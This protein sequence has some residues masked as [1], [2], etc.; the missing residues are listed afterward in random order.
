ML[1]FLAIGPARVSC[2]ELFPR[3]AP[4]RH[5][6]TSPSRSPELPPCV[7]PVRCS[8]ERLAC[9]PD[10]LAASPSLHPSPTPP[11][12]PPCSP[13]RLAF[14]RAPP[15]VLRSPVLPRASCVPPCSPERLAF[16]RAPRASCVPPCSPERLAFPRAPPS[17]LRSPV[18]PRASCVPPCSPER[19]AFPRAPPSVLRSPVLPRASCVP[20]CSP[21]RLAFPRAPP[22]VLRVPRVGWR[23]PQ[24]SIRVRL[25]R[26][27]P[28]CTA[29]PSLSFFP[30]DPCAP[31]SG[32]EPS[33]PFPFGP[34]PNS[35][36]V[37][38]PRSPAPVG[39]VKT[40]LLP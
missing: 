10:W 11:S 21:E 19:L 4:A 6:C 34:G 2:L 22:S 23:L 35:F 5:S 8:P 31:P 38:L 37:D 24:A 3:T 30:R 29:P 9:S 17:V 1:P 7:S 18:L 26:A 12:V 15:S 39:L 16:P 20:P 27:L 28:L 40:I 33:V 13:E 32:P 14:P 36:P 25:P